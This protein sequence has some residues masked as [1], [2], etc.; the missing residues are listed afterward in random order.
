[1][2]WM[3]VEYNYNMEQ[4]ELENLIEKLIKLGEDKSEL[5][6]WLKLYPDL[7]PDEQEKLVKNLENELSQLEKLKK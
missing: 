4:A 2:K 3:K 5:N 6:F 7:E 1:M